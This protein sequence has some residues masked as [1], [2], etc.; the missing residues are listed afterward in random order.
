MDREDMQYIHAEADRRRQQVTRPSWGGSIAITLASAAVG[1]QEWGTVSAIIVGSDSQPWRKDLSPAG[2]SSQ[3][4]SCLAR[5]GGGRG[6]CPT[7]WA[8]LAGPD[9]VRCPVRGGFFFRIVIPKKTL[10]YTTYQGPALLST[11]TA[12]VDGESDQKY[13][14]TSGSKNMDG[15]LHHG[16]GGI[17]PEDEGECD[18][19]FSPLRHT[20]STRNQWNSKTD[21][22]SHRNSQPNTIIVIAAWL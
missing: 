18:N 8:W 15:T 17:T 13:C 4:R 10:P 2:W 3:R 19:R 11:M 1:N 9:R 5:V 21:L 22:P 6:S 16:S 12:S 20:V 14:P 7:F